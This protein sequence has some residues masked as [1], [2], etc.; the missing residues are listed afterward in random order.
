MK[1][2][3]AGKTIVEVIA[4]PKDVPWDGR[5]QTS[6]TIEGGICKIVLSNEAF[7]DP[8]RANTAYRRFAKR[9]TK[10]G[11]NPPNIHFRNMAS[12]ASKNI[13]CILTANESVFNSACE[14]KRMYLVESGKGESRRVGAVL[15]REDDRMMEEA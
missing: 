11:F 14:V 2:F 13:F 1:T 3:E 6:S 9:M 7:H 15:L 12:N 8:S 10:E 5:Y 4:W